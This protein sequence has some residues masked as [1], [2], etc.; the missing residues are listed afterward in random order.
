MTDP[1]YLPQI[2]E[3]NELPISQHALAHLKQLKFPVDS[4]SLYCV[5]LLSWALEAGKL[6][7]PENLEP[8]IEQMPDEDPE[9]VAM[10][11]NLEEQQIQNGPAWTAQQL[12]E[13]LKYRA[14]EL[15][16]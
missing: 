9:K 5:Q 6:D 3:I 7:L 16:L 10:M 13:E 1:R 15:D 12:A 4:A 14:I 11:L 8:W 2:K